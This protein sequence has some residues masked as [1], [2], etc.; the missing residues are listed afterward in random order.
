MGIF[1]EERRRREEELRASQSGVKTTRQLTTQEKVFG[2]RDQQQTR[3][4]IYRDLYD[5]TIGS[6]TAGAAETGRLIAEGT[7]LGETGPVK[8]FALTMERFGREHPEYQPEEVDSA[9]DLIKSP[10]ALSSRVF[11]AAPQMAAGMGA[12]GVPYVGL[13]LAAGLSYTV[14]SR[15]AYEG[16]LAYGASQD[17]A[18]A[19]GRSTGAASAIFDVLTNQ[20]IINF[21]KGQRGL[22]ARNAE[23]RVSRMIKAT[24][25]S[26]DFVGSI[27]SAAT[28]NAMQGAVSDGIANLTYGR[29][30]DEGFFDRRIQEGI[31]GAV[32]AGAVGP[33]VKYFTH[34]APQ[35]DGTVRQ[36]KVDSYDR[37]SFR[38]FLVDDH[39]MDPGP[40]THM[41][42]LVDAYA[43]NWASRNN[44]NVEEFYGMQ[45]APTDSTGTNLAGASEGLPRLFF[46]KDPKKVLRGFIDSAQMMLS[47]GDVQVMKDNNLNT[48]KL[49]S[50]AFER[51][52]ADGLAPAPELVEPFEMFKDVLRDNWRTTKDAMGPLTKE[53]SAKADA[54]S[55]IST[56][57][58][59]AFD[60]MLSVDTDLIVEARRRLGLGEDLSS[61]IKGAIR[62]RDKALQF[63]E[64]IERISQEAS[65]RLDALLSER[66]MTPP[67]DP[68]RTALDTRIRLA[69]EEV[70][71]NQERLRAIYVTPSRDE[72]RVDPEKGV[73]VEH[74][75]GDLEAQEKMNERMRWDLHAL[76]LGRLLPDRDSNIARRASESGTIREIL[77]LETPTEK[78]RRN[79]VQRSMDWWQ[80]MVAEE[81]APLRPY[82]SGRIALEALDD[83][84]SHQRSIEGEYA[85]DNWR[86]YHGL[87]KRDRQWL[88]EFD[89]AQAQQDGYWFDNFHRLIETVGVPNSIPKAPSKAVEGLRQQA[90]K[91]LVTL[92]NTFSREGGLFKIG[93]DIIPFK[94]PNE[95]R[96]LRFVTDDFREAVIR[97]E[98]ETFD[99]IQK[100]VKKL[101]PDQKLS[102]SGVKSVL[103][104]YAA[105]TGIR[106]S[107]PLTDARAI[108]IIPTGVIVNGKKVQLLHTEPL[109]YLTRAVRTQAYQ[110]GWNRV[111]GDTDLAKAETKNMKGFLEELGVEAPYNINTLK[112]RFAKKGIEVPEHITDLKQLEAAAKAIKLQTGPRRKDYL[113]AIDKLTVNDITKERLPA[114]KAFAKKIGGVDPDLS[115]VG[116]LDEVKRRVKEN[117]VDPISLLSD[118]IGAEG[119]D[120]GL[121]NKLVKLS[122]GVPV[123]RTAKGGFLERH[124]AMRVTKLFSGVLGSAQTS[125]S[126][127]PNI[128]QTLV[129]VPQMVGL[130]NFAGA[131]EAVFKDRRGVEQGLIAIGAINDTHRAW[132]LERGYM[133]EGIS[134][135]LAQSVQ[136]IT[137]MKWVS[138]VNNAIAGESFNRLAKQWQKEPSSFTSKDV[139]LAKTLRLNDAQIK[140]I[141]EG[142]MS[143]QTF[144]KIV[145]TGVAVTQFVTESGHRRAFVENHPIMKVL[146][147]YNSYAAGTAR[148]TADFYRS[149]K[150]VKSKEDAANMLYRTGLWLGGAMGAGFLGEAMRN[151]IRGD[152]AREE[153]QDWMER[154]LGAFLSVQLFGPTQRMFESQRYSKGS[155][156]NWAMGM[157][158]QV[159][160]LFEFLGYAS[161]MAFGSE[162]GR[163]GGFDAWRQTKE[164][165]KFTT[166]AVRAAMRWQEQVAYPNTPVYNEIKASVGKWQG[167]VM[168]KKSKV[169]ETQLNPKYDDVWRWT[170]RND[171][172]MAMKAAQEYYDGEM[173]EFKGDPERAVQMGLSFD[174]SRRGLRSSLTQRAPLNL[175]PHLLGQYMNSI[176]QDK[177]E[178]YWKVHRQYMEIVNAVAPTN[179]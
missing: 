72:V 124:P 88:A 85:E 131:V 112:E 172:E 28:F 10:G 173:K 60:R 21:A 39:Q 154:G 125:T 105:G 139:G 41:A 150:Q 37:D 128:P 119:G 46:D 162:F 98:G 24:G 16:A 62:E 82:P 100:A 133:I 168:E 52:L 18:E 19:A 59:A 164:F 175:N 86:T 71:K 67:D 136:K 177:Q 127:V 84:H 55:P 89:E 20:R 50:D 138:D 145:Q 137:G 76:Q 31:T 87:P 1:D 99:A 54:P 70:K 36:V 58:R 92:G 27:T 163:Y 45:M 178:Q 65:D 7:P 158:P 156:Q 148:A 12:L 122:Q 149:W 5:V 135:N 25:A 96:M 32:T 152:V 120:R 101:N 95:L 151:V 56:E 8:A 57:V 9:W 94:Q 113:T 38:E 40:A 102:D 134:R 115:P 108:K 116:L 42:E 49:M 144:A 2:A 170:V 171:P 166:P 77:R 79:G 107:G 4:P 118:N 51:Y 35:P 53:E 130:K 81:A 23:S 117:P 141:R 157:M 167:D 34:Q 129:Q 22:L 159:N 48:P 143:N 123:H 165:V 73:T 33:L 66:S 126:V 174:R 29:D 44:K 153:K 83:V 30:I 11:N 69:N 63:G 93:D 3:G 114:L 14:E 13:P 121:F 90:K 111:I 64:D 140:E 26:P 103:N 80:G 43:R 75:P 155:V 179:N 61:K 97:G 147:A 6:L 106:E 142:K 74:I 146:F 169:G 78:V 160:A 176:P 104:D 132:A 161:N 15:R 110:I 91:I 109:G 17:Q 68:R 47:P